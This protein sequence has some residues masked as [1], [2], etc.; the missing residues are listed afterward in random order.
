MQQKTYLSF[1]AL[2][3][4]QNLYSYHQYWKESQN[5]PMLQRIENEIRIFKMNHNMAD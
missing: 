1:K 2:K 3:E 5:E 4:L